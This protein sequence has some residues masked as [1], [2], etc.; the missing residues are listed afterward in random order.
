MSEYHSMEISANK[1]YLDYLKMVSQ[2]SKRIFD[3]WEA[4]G[5]KIQR[6]LLFPNNNLNNHPYSVDAFL[7]K[8]RILV[9]IDGVLYHRNTE[10]DKIRDRH[11]EAIASS[12][13]HECKIVRIPLA[14]PDNLIYGELRKKKKV[15]KKEEYLIWLKA[16][17]DL[18][19]LK[20]QAQTK[21]TVC[22]QLEASSTVT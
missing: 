11:I 6:E 12:T 7:V 15:E 2:A 21:K 1:T 17:A 20:L 13:G 8:E 16:F 3:H 19:L 22:N 10:R 14:I 5:V 4:S 9:E 18:E